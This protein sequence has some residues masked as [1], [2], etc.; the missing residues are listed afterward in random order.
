MEIVSFLKM[1]MDVWN[2]AEEKGLKLSLIHILAGNVMGEFQRTKVIPEIDAY[3]YSTIAQLAETKGK[4]K[5][6]TPAADTILETLDVYKRQGN[7]W[8][9]RWTSISRG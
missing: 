5:D 8:A 2:E 6:Y 4:K 1:W 9:V 7:M 3:R